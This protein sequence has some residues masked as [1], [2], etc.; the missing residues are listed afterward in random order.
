[1]SLINLSEEYKRNF[2]PPL[3]ERIR[4]AFDLDLYW[5]SSLSSIEEHFRPYPPAKTDRGSSMKSA[6]VVIRD[7]EIKRMYPD[8]F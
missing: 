5:A 6:K 8:S 2:N 1:M 4:M 7:L 3:Y